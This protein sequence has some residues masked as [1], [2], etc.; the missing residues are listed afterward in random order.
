VTES[1]DAAAQLSSGIP[2]DKLVM[3]HG[4]ISAKKA[5]ELGT[6][7]ESLVIRKESRPILAQ[8]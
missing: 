1:L 7:D 3:A 8:L 2:L 4:P 5:R 6:I